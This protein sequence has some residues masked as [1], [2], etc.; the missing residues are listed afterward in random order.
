MFEARS[1]RSL[2]G[3]DSDRCHCHVEALLEPPRRPKAS[4]PGSTSATSAS[5]QRRVERSIA[6]T[7]G[8][9]VAAGSLIHGIASRLRARSSASIS[10]KDNDDEDTDDGEDGIY[11]E[12]DG[13]HR[14]DAEEYFKIWHTDGVEGNKDE[15]NSCADDKDC[16][17]GSLDVL[18]SLVPVDMGSIIL[19]DDT[20]DGDDNSSTDTEDVDWSP[21]KAGNRARMKRAKPPVCLKLKLKTDP[22]LDD[23]LNTIRNDDND[24]QITDKCGSESAVDAKRGHKTSLPPKSLTSKLK[25]IGH[26]K[27]RSKVGPKWEKKVSIQLLK[28]I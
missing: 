17:T 26:K 10:Y 13:P 5:G 3:A 19:D 20:V 4:V 21:K 15:P 16:G 8:T 25:H 27:S 1:G 9:P 24:H 22:V 23:E 28:I 11:I 18:E 12:N 14:E 6:R 7:N 2:F